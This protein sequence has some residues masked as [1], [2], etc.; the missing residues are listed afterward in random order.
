[1][2]I[3]ESMHKLVPCTACRYCCDGCPAGLDIPSLLAF[4]NDMSFQPSVNIG[5]RLEVLPE[6]KKPSACLGC[7]K[8]EKACPQGIEIPKLLN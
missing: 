8:C 5:M 4:Y 1:M 7:G 2:S 6:D 3:A